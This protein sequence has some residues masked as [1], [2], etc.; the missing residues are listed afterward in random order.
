MML[1]HMGEHPP[2]T[3]VQRAAIAKT[4]RTCVEAFPGRLRGLALV[5]RSS[6]QRGIITAINWVA[7]PPYPIAA[8]KTEA[9]AEAWLF[10]VYGRGAEPNRPRSQRDP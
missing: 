4:M 5:V 6:I 10:T 8:F 3:P 2:L 9:D 1:I 7:S